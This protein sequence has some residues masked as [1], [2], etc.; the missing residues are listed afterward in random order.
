MIIE[1]T[2]ERQLKGNDLK[3]QLQW[4]YADK[5]F[6]HGSCVL[7]AITGFGKTRAGITVIDRIRQQSDDPIIIVVPTL[8]LKDDWLLQTKQYSNVF[9]YVI[10]TFTMTEDYEK[11]GIITKCICVIFDEV[12]H[13]LNDE[14]QYFST[15]LDKVEARFKVLLSA[16]LEQKH[17]DFLKSK[18][19]DTYFKVSHYWAY[20]NGLVPENYSVNVPVSLTKEEKIQYVNIEKTIQKYQK[21]FFPVGIFHPYTNTWSK[22]VKEVAKE[23]GWIN[24]N[25]ISDRSSGW[26]VQSEAKAVGSVFGSAKAW[27]NAINN[28]KLLL[29]NA[30][31]KKIV[32]N[33]LLNKIG[34]TER[35][36]IFTKSV[37]SLEYIVSD[38]KLAVG[39]HGKMSKKEKEQALL[40]FHTG[41]RPRL[42]SIEMLKEGFNI[43][44]C[45]YAVNYSYTSK[46][47]D[48]TQKIGR[49]LRLDPNNPD[50]VAVFFTLYVKDFILGEDY[51]DSQEKKWLEKS[52]KGKLVYEIDKI[53]LW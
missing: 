45:S 31:N 32:L 40:A 9:V 47:L 21:I 6:K 11:K 48:N 43:E 12:H 29:Y 37:E 22:T 33:E 49:I 15:A 17:K 53:K 4:T 34:E 10:N 35:V 16:T 30:E 7:E 28:R 27:S 36:L 2:N 50:K 18:G 42:V 19:I 5:V 23:L 3:T 13:C 38:D 44:G 26:T 14:S 20:K 41:F 8:K 1:A 24:S 39:Y 46:E 52:Q 51:Y 25:N